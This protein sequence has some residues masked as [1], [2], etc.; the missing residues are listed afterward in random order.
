MRMCPDINLVSIEKKK[1]QRIVSHEKHNVKNISP[2]E[3]L[4]SVFMQLLLYYSVIKWMDEN[5]YIEWD[6]SSD[7]LKWNESL[8]T[9][10]IW[11]FDDS[12]K[13]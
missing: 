11:N 10:N 9:W 5:K 7:L 1:K 12:N 4:A 6:A 3:Q 8:H 2:N 13:Y